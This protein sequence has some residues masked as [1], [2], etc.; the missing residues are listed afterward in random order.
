MTRN[1]FGVVHN[2]ILV[3]RNTEKLTNNWYVA[4]IDAGSWREQA[5]GSTGISSTWFISWA[6]S[7][8]G[9]GKHNLFIGCRECSTND[10]VGSKEYA[11]NWNT[12]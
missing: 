5:W 7:R 1:M 9:Q 10:I 12:T 8:I 3:G 4:W 2:G 6:V 11:V